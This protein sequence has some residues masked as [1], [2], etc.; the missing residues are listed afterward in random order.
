[1]SKPSNG[2]SLQREHC[3]T[4][5]DIELDALPWLDDPEPT[6]D[7]SAEDDSELAWAA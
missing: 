3:N 6:H 7:T 4:L 2:P 1:M 5:P